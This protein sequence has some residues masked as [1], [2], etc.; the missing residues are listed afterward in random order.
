MECCLLSIDLSVI[1]TEYLV[2]RFLEA[3]LFGRT[4]PNTL[5]TTD[6]VLMDLLDSFMRD[7]DHAIKM[8]N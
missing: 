7:C 2:L 3:K 8:I 1:L 5:L 4:L 6:L